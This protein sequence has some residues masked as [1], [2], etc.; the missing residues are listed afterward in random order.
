[1][2]KW[3]VYILLCADDS[4]YTGVTNDVD[5]RYA[6]HETGINKGCYTYHRR[7]VTLVYQDY[8]LSPEAAIE[9]EKQIKGWNRKKK[10]AL[11]EGDFNKLRELAVCTNET[12]HKQYKPVEDS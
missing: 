4:Y 5:R 7:P 12:T 2:K 11:I 8:F 3:Y 9:A 6:E 1:M 10:E